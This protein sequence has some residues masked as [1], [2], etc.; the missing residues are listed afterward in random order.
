MTQLVF[1]VRDS[2][3]QAFLQ[4]FFSNSSGAAIRAFG[5]AVMD[6]KSPLG[7]HPTDYLLYELGTFDDNSGMFVAYPTIKLLSAGADFFPTKPLTP[8]VNVNGKEG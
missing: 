4:P 3:A 1:G 5:D 7:L 8:E 2:K 6:T